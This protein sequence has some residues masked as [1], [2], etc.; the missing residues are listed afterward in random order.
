MIK[1]LRITTVLESMINAPGSSKIK[2]EM[3]SRGV[4]IGPSDR[5]E[6]R[7]EY[8]ILYILPFY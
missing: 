5:V 7:D 6:F 1:F 4:L 2:V 3:I 8:G